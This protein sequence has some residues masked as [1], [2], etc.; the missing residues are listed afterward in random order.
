MMSAKK[1]PDSVS[2]ATNRVIPRTVGM[3]RVEAAVTV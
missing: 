1:F 3:S 2:M